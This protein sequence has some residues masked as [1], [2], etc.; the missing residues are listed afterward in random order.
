VRGRRKAQQQLACG[1]KELFA[2][3]AQSGEKFSK[4]RAAAGMFE[5]ACFAQRNS[6][7]Q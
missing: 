3:Q 1:L 7:Q 2:S 4:A 6:R 5:L